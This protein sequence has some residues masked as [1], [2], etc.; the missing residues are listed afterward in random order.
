MKFMRFWKN[1]PGK[2]REDRIG[3]MAAETVET[4]TMATE[5]VAN[6]EIGL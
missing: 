5:L 6:G 4:G 2:K 3:T 1:H